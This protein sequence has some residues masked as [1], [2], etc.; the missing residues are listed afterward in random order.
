MSDFESMPIIRKADKYDQFVIGSKDVIQEAR[1]LGYLEHLEGD[2][3]ELVGTVFKNVQQDPGS[4]AN[5]N[6]LQKLTIVHELSEDT[7]VSSR[8]SM[9]GIHVSEGP[10]GQAQFHYMD[11]D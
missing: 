3:G 9:W 4:P 7:E 6:F 11:E 5:E 1:A 2:L 10:E 8:I